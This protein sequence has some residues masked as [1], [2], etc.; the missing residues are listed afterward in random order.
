ME[1]SEL[2]DLQSLPLRYKLLITDARIQDWCEHW[3]GKVYVSLSGGKDSLVL[4]HRVRRLYP[5]VVAV[6][7]D[8]GLEYPALKQLVR[9]IPNVIIIRPKMSF[10]QVLKKYGYPIISKQQAA[11][12]R[13]LTTQNLSPVYRNKLLYGDEK[14]KAGMLSKKWHYLLDAPF[15]ISEKCC[16]VMKKNPLKK[17]HAETGLYPFTGEMASEGGTRKSNYLK[18]GCNAFD[19]DYPKS[20]PLGFWTDQDVYEYILENNIEIPEVY[21]QIV[22]RCG[23]WTTTGERR[24][25]CIFCAFGCHLEKGENRFQRMYHTYPELYNYCIK[26]LDLGYV[27]DYIGVD[28]SPKRKPNVINFT[29]IKPMGRNDK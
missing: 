8:T 3:N 19:L 4:L 24:T 10:R 22:K 25:G 5:D 2:K 17:F 6:F 11:A 7:V 20:M 15:K 23:K 18:T 28:Y 14:G 13:K 1:Y 9:R 16:D 29:E 27:L 26:D 12:I 21:G